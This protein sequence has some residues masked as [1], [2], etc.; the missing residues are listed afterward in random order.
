M[1]VVSIKYLHQPLRVHNWEVLIHFHVHGKGKDLFG[2]GFAFWYTK[3]RGPFGKPV[4]VDLPLLHT[5]SAGP[6]FGSADY[7]TGLG[8]FFDTYSNYN[9]EHS[10]S[11]RVLSNR[12]HTPAYLKTDE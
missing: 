10:V 12:G 3:H 5:L 8:I 4:A 6:I 11:F 9:G 2:D 1:I 7:F